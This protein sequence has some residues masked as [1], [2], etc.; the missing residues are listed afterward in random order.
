MRNEKIFFRLKK[1]IS[2]VKNKKESKKFN[3][4]NY[5]KFA[6]YTKEN[7]KFFVN[8]VINGYAISVLYLENIRVII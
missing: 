8:F 1:L 2:L 6:K 4:E 7:K 3:Q 5:K